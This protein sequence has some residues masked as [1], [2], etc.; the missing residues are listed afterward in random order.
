MKTG[1]E[2]VFKSLGGKMCFVLNSF[3]TEHEH[4]QLQTLSIVLVRFSDNEQLS[5]VLYSHTQSKVGIEHSRLLLR[6]D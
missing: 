2:R 3:V 5:A 4:L 6:K 1:G